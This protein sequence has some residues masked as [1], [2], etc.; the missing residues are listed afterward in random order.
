MYCGYSVG[1]DKQ[2]HILKSGQAYNDNEWHAV[3]VEKDDPR[4][5]LYIDGALQDSLSDEN[6]VFDRYVELNVSVVYLYT[7]WDASLV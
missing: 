4:T 3:V 6:S 1:R 7:G 2:K 5:T